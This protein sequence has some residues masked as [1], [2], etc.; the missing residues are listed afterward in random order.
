MNYTFRP[1]SAAEFDTIKAIMRGVEWDEHY[2]DAH[3]VAAEKFTK[4]DE[5]EVYVA[6][7]N[8]DIIGFMSLKH[9]RINFL[10][11]VYGLVVAKAFQGQGLGKALMEFAE[12]RARARGNRGVFLDTPDDNTQART[13]YKAAGYQEGYRMPKYY[14]DELDAITYLKLFNVKL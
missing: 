11:Y 8:D 5:G 4:D 1:I 10:T 13:F 2:V 6:T 9:Q 12:Q 7:L 3:A 14:T